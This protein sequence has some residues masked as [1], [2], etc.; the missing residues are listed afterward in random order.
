MSIISRTILLLQTEM[1]RPKPYGW[2]HIFFILIMLLTIFILYR[3]RNYTE[4]KLKVVLA[5]YGITSLLLEILKQISWAFTYDSIKNLLLFDYEWY[6]FPFQLC[7]TP[8]YVSII[9]LFLNKNKVRDSLLSYL[10]FVTIL[11]SVSTILLPES[12]FVTDILV[13]IHTMYLHLG[14]FVVSVYLL[15]SEEVKLNV[16]SLFNGIIMFI[17]FVFIANSLNITIYNLNILNGETF[18]MFYISPYFISSLPVFNIIQANVPYILF[19]IIYLWAIILGSI[20]IFFIT[21]IIKKVNLY[22]KHNKNKIK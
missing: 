10:A 15:I 11:G 7:T 12:C 8:I 5:F 16:K 9:C 21:L 1:E 17:I 13:N 22:V 2:F 19:L 14:S 18:N 4:K 20:I 6:A 3:K